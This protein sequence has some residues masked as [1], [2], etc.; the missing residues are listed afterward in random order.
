MEEEYEYCWVRE[1]PNKAEFIVEYDSG[2]VTNDTLKICGYHLTQLPFKKFV[3][4]R[5]KYNKC[6][7]K[8]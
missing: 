2:P 3:L 8:F 1:C 6:F 4:K 5:R 7:T